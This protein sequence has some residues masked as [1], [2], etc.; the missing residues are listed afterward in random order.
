MKIYPFPL[1][2]IA[3]LSDIVE[4]RQ[5]ALI[6]SSPAWS[7]IKEKF[8]IS[9]QCK[10]IVSEATHEHWDNLTETIVNCHPEVIYAIGGGLAADSGK[11]ISAKLDLQLVCIPTA[12]TVDAFFTWASGIRKEGCVI[13]V[14]TKPPDLVWVDLDV[15]A[16][17]PHSLRA[18]G[19]TDVLSI[20]TGLWDWK[21]AEERNQNPG[22]MVYLPWAAKL[23][24]NIL[25]SAMDCAEAAG[26][27]NKAGL[28]QLLDCLCLEVQLCNQ[29]G[30]SRPEEGS[31]H[32]F[33]YAVENLVGKGFLH[34]ELVGPGIM[35]I[36]NIQG[37]DTTRL[38]NAL[39]SCH[40]PLDKLRPT[41]VS[42]TLYHL[43]SYVRKHQLP[44]GIAH[45]LGE[46]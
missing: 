36:A 40:I 5:A 13:Y 3:P 20:A 16:G 10:F 32:Y 1:I 19:I 44:Y 33:A 46:K 26:N 6:T 12:L 45:V 4:K 18:A 17:A 8:S 42:E 28:K 22:E 34:G 11:Y 9:F 27:G 15:L 21:F 2:E 7:S 29:I 14:E 37:Q 38:K 39:R 43:P 31:E 35:I 23:A 24:E 30:H 41:I 25:D